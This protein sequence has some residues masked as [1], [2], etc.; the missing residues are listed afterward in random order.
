MP[1]KLKH[2]SQNIKALLGPLAFLSV[3]FLLGAGSSCSGYHIVRSGQGNVLAQKG[4]HQIYIAPVSNQS[5]HPGIEIAVFNEIQ[6][7]I[8]ANGLV[9]VVQKVEEAD[10]VL[11]A[12]V[13]SAAY[14]QSSITG[15]NNIFPR[16]VGPKDI[17]V[18]TEYTAALGCQF[19]LK[20]TQAFRDR[21]RVKAMKLTM[22]SEPQTLW[23]GQFNRSRPFPGN[24]QIGPFGSTSS[25]INNSEFDRTL[26]ELAENMM[27]DVHDSMLTMF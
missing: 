25:L 26:K 15:A 22:P 10:A 23:S 14:V 4:I 18:A 20:E 24:N 12:R 21:L 7:V 11:E 3:S 16:E 1:A 17:S 9:Q 19:T 6:K 2:F 27:Y 8:V 13:I 5:F